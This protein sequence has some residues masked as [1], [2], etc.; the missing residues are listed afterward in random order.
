[1]L[2][3]TWKSL[4]IMNKGYIFFSTEIQGF[5]IISKVIKDFMQKQIPTS[6]YLHASFIQE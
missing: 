5:G 6:F 4:D 1:M 3:T 2:Y